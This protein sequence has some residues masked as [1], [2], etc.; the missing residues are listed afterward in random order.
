MHRDLKPASIA[1]RENGE[2]TILDFGRARL[3]EDAVKTTYVQTR[4]Y[5]APEVIYGMVER[6]GEQSEFF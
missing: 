4:H 2:V 6:Y 3:A 5:R 1:V